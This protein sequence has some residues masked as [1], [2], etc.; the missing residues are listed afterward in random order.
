M[1]KKP[2]RGS[3]CRARKLT[4]L[5]RGLLSRHHNQGNYAEAEALYRR[6]LAVREKALDPDH[7][8]V[9]TSRRSHQIGG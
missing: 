9:G 6:A 7:P 8:V 5:L 3:T 4:G 1:A 2:A